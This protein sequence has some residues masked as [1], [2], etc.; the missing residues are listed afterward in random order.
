MNIIEKENI[1]AL[2]RINENLKELDD[3]VEKK[4]SRSS[5]N[6]PILSNIDMNG[7]SILNC[8]S[9]DNNISFSPDEY[10]LKSD[11]DINDDGVVDE[12]KEVNHVGTIDPL[13]YY[14]TDSAGLIGFH[15][16]PIGIGNMQKA[17]YD[18]NDDGVVENVDLS[19]TSSSA[20][21]AVTTNAVTS[22]TGTTSK[23]Y[24]AAS[25]VK[26]AQTFSD[27][28]PS[29]GIIIW[30]GTIVS[31]PDGW[32]IC[33]G[34]NGTPNLTDRFILHADGVTNNVDDTGVAAGSV[35]S[36]AVSIA[37]MPPHRHSI[38]MKTARS[39]GTD[40]T[41]LGM[42]FSPTTATDTQMVSTTGSGNTH[43]HSITSFKPKYYA[44]AYIMKA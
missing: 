11:Y 43:D 38:T 27:L 13:H 28:M 7:Y 1:N 39:D 9:I 35:S 20:T 32:Y 5:I 18:T 44:L 21:S 42:F 10:L 14:G 37:E 33:D 15:A 23:Y 31:I 26:G 17:V 41:A 12:V 34:A 24:G 30:S 40:G 22:I 6:G 36:V 4:L 29:G 16:F 2:H 25:G 8:P 19:Y 3:D